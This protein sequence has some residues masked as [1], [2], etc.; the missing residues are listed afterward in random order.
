METTEKF[1]EL[2]WVGESRSR[3]CTLELLAAVDAFQAGEELA[4]KDATQDSDG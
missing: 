1:C 3:A 4:A 2:L